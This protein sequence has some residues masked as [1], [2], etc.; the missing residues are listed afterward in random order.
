MSRGSPQGLLFFGHLTKI[1][2]TVTVTVMKQTE[3]TEHAKHCDRWILDT[4]NPIIIEGQLQDL[5]RFSSSK[6]VLKSVPSSFMALNYYGTG[7][8]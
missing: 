4:A 6:L 8:S 3:N 5:Q 2:V 1:T 7:S